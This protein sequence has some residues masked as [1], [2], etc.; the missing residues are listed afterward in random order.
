MDVNAARA[1]GVTALIWAAHWND[2]ETV[3]L[4]LGARANVN[5]ADDHGVT[6]LARACENASAA[7]VDRLL[8]AG[9]NPNL[10]QESGLT[11][12]MI[13]ARTGSVAVGKALVARGAKVNAATAGAEATALMWAI[14]GGHRE[15]VRA[16][17]RGRRRRAPLHVEGL[18][19]A[20]VRG[21]QR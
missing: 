20:A 11:P 1:D 8:A 2:L 12:L 9:A 13:A 10:A 17:D 4:L 5:A 14:S 16:A 7:I 3:T 15:F 18:H 19:A 21:A 6:A